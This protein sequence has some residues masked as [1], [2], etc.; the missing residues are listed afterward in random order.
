[1]NLCIWKKGW[2]HQYV[3]S[4]DISEVLDA[5]QALYPVNS[6]TDIPK[7]KSKIIS[8]SFKDNQYRVCLD[9]R[10][11]LS[12]F[13]IQT[14]SNFLFQDVRYLP[15][16][17][18]LHGGAIAVADHVQIFLASTGTGKTTLTA[19]LVNKGCPY[20]NDDYVLIEMD[21]LSVI[22]NCSPLHLR[23]E[24]IPILKRY[25]CDIQGTEVKMETERRIAYLPKNT[26]KE[27]LQIG[28]IFILDHN[29]TENS[30]ERLS[31]VRT[32]QCLLANSL[33]FTTNGVEK[34]QC[35]IKLA[36]RFPCIRLRYTD[37][38]FVADYIAHI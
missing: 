26:V 34:L 14:I 31:P 11:T 20:L 17:F 9:G 8:V 3:V 7:L 24:S 29:V 22:P 27:P 35:A 6:M 18:P 28:R 5:L 16:L 37:L 1:M 25:G 13:P 23:P 30:Y 4:C 32:V 38:N 15:T 2:A 12:N 33:S 19:F 21:T 10:M 36:N